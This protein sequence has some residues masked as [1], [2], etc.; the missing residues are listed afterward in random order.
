[1]STP[2]LLAETDAKMIDG[3]TLA[4][5]LKYLIMTISGKGQGDRVKSDWQGT[6]YEISINTLSLPLS[7]RQNIW[8]YLI[9]LS[10][11]KSAYASRLV[12][13]VID[14]C[15]IIL[16]LVLASIFRV[17]FEFLEALGP[18]KLAL[19]LVLLVRL[20]SFSWFRTYAVIIRYACVISDKTSHL[21]KWSLSSQKDISTCL[22]Y[23]SD[24]ADE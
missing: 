2:R 10:Y 19:T 15:L 1:M 18:V 11:S 5:Y 3:L 17:N 21:R 16:A 24:A 22:L 12:V 13:L 4:N 6:L 8:W 20:I 23:T 9:V 7:L 14:V